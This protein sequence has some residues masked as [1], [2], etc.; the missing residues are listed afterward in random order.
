MDNLQNSM[1]KILTSDITSDIIS[2]TNETIIK[3]TQEINKGME[4]IIR[5][6]EEEEEEGEGEIIGKR[7]NENGKIE[8]IKKKIINESD[9]I[10]HFLYDTFTKLTKSPKLNDNIEK[11][12][13][14]AENGLKDGSVFS[15]L[16]E[17]VENQDIEN[18]YNKEMQKLKTNNVFFFGL[19]SAVMS[20][21]SRTCKKAIIVD[22]DNPVIQLCVKVL[23]KLQ[24]RDNSMSGGSN[25]KSKSALIQKYI[26]MSFEKLLKTIG[27][28]GAV[29]CL[30]LLIILIGIA[31]PALGIILCV[32]GVILGC[33][34]VFYGD[35]LEKLI[36]QSITKME[37]EEKR[38]GLENGIIEN[39]IISNRIEEEGG[40]KQKRN[41][42]RK[43]NFRQNKK[44]TERKNRYY[45]LT[46]KRS[47]RSKRSKRYKRSK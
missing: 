24:V 39:G 31:A 6:E 18:E 9:G 8:D 42:R 4:T 40:K 46:R 28:A 41:T 20:Y 17:M 27:V 5:I 36:K 43:R 38:L 26:I 21:I 34:L 22:H 7:I 14:V 35:T 30:T 23:N 2:P 12:K 3:K 25:N 45:K 32:L 33:L 13:I 15:Y 37:A 11:M 44:N 16:E 10:I 1:N 29:F 19:T 47:K